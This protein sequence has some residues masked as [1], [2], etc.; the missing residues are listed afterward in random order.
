[1]TVPLIASAQQANC[2]QCWQT[3][4]KP[5]GP[6]WDHLARYQRAGRRGLISQDELERA[7]LFAVAVGGIQIVLHADG[8]QL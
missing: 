4:G 6:G 2:G 8:S 3:P 7:R 1:V 5:C